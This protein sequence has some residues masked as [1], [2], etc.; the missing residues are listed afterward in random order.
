MP[1]VGPVMPQQVM[2]ATEPVVPQAV[3]PAVESIVPEQPVVSVPEAP[4]AP[5]PVIYGGANPSIGNIEFNQNA[6]H[7]IYGGANPLENTQPI[8]IGV[9]PSVQPVVNNDPTIV[10]PQTVPYTSNET[11]Q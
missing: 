6:N 3:M 8:S 10:Q 7:Q 11:L 5:Q 2:P 4:V 9:V 1:A